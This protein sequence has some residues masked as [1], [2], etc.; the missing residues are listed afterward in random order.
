[1]RLLVTGASGFTGRHLISLAQAAGHSVSVL[2]AN[3]TDV[4]AIR[5]ALSACGPLD[6][7]LHL[8]GIAFVGHADNA[9]FYAVNT[10]GT[11]NLLQ[12]LVSETAAARRPRV[13]I[14]SSANVYGNC[15]RSPISEE[16]APAPVNHYAASKLA[17]EHMALTHADRLSVVIARPFNYTGPGQSP[18]FL[19]PKLV[20]HFARR[21]PQIELGNLHVE[22]EFND[23]RM[24]CEAYLALL[25][26]GQPGETYNICSG[27]THSLQGVMDR[28]ER[29]TGHQMAV[30]VNPAFVRASEVHRLCGSPDK[31]LGCV[32]ELAPYTLGDTLQSMLDAAA[33]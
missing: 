14:A 1:M 16:Q 18:S 30:A 33:A 15:E 21:A 28:L 3:L 29:L 32:G 12:C 27:Q 19:I 31:L 25:N 23:V 9:A 6:A 5:L 11:T 4:N 2:E 17:M 22:R 8:A 24:V 20:D 26:K 7:V 13:L 10:V